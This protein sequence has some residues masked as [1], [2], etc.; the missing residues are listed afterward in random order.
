MVW[1]DY[2]RDWKST[3]RR[4][5]ELESQVTQAQLQAATRAVDSN[6]LKQFQAQQQTAQKN[7]SANQQKVD[8]L[9]AKLKDADVRL[10]RATLDYQYTKA[11]YDQDRYDFEATRA[12]KLPSD[13]KQHHVE[14]L[15]KRLN[16]LNMDR[17]K[18]EA[19]KAEIQK[20]LGQYTG[21]VTVIGKQIE[22]MTA[23][24]TAAQAPAVV[25]PAREG[26]FPERTAFHGMTIKIQQ[27][28]LPN[29]V[30]DV[31]SSA[32]QMDGARPAIS[33]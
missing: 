12:N 6:K 25:A 17:E 15:S 8:E 2:D 14:E 16:D 3:Q 32:C 33:P 5:S 20:Q 22:E 10:N 27:I 4:F 31:I 30:D 24:R 11:T 13:K 19:E 29:V 28:I 9:Q 1:D 23:G 26:L 21:Q 18:A 7:V